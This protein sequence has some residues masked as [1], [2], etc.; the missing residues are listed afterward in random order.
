MFYNFVIVFVIGFSSLD[1][2]IIS[3]NEQQLITR[4]WRRQ[5]TITDKI[6]HLLS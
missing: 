1:I 6:K 2:K 3:E 4:S 5:N